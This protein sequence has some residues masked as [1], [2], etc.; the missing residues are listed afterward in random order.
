MKKTILPQKL[1]RVLFI[2][3]SVMV[4]A[5]CHLVL[6]KITQDGEGLAGVNVTI[7]GAEET[8]VTTDPQ[9]NYAFFVL[10]GGDYTI[11]PSFLDED[12]RSSASRISMSCVPI[13]SNASAQSI[14]FAS[15]FTRCDSQ[16]SPTLGIMLAV[17]AT[18]LRLDSILFFR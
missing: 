17:S 6:G 8:T 3:L 16:L 2:F 10:E 5:G 7:S 11:T 13:G 1:I 12:E 14:W 18:V 4:F 9:G 15:L